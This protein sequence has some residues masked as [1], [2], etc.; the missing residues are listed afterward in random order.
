MGIEYIEEAFRASGRTLAVGESAFV[1][2]T[3]E[4]KDAPADDEEPTES[5]CIL[6]MMDNGRLSACHVR[7]LKQ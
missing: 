3:G 7:V 2:L 1:T 6:T 4:V 5:G